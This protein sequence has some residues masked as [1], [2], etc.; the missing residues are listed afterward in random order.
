MLRRRTILGAALDGTSLP[1]A[2]TAAAASHSLEAKVTPGTQFKLKYAP[3]F[4]MFDN[5]SDGEV[6]TQLEFM[7]AEG[8]RAMEHG[9]SRGGAEGEQAVIDAYRAVDNF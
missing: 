1:L 9:N 6:V 8:F 4:D 3:H 2:S 7:A 5:L